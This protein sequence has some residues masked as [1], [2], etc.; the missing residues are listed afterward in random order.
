LA[1]WAFADQFSNYLPNDAPVDG[2][3]LYGGEKVLIQLRGSAKRRQIAP[4]RPIK[5]A[6]LA[7]YG[8][9]FEQSQR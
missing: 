3:L 1:N 6:R 5:R 8:E 9:T 7:G 2:F 4:G